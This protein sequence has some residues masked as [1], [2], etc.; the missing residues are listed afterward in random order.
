MKKLYS[1][2]IILRMSAI[3]SALSLAACTT[4]RYQDGT[5]KFT[6]TSFG[7]NL[8]ITELRASTAP[9]GARTITLQGYTSDQ[10]EALRAVA[11]GVAKGF[12]AAVK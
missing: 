4:I 2:R 5:S 6:R 1:F 11:E 7:T 8:Q 10:V 3:C 9:N 12:S